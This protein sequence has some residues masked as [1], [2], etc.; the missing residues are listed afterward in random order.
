MSEV[1]NV[2]LELGVLTGKRLVLGGEVTDLCGSLDE[3]GLE[4]VALGSEVID[5]VGKLGVGMGKSMNLCGEL[6]YLFL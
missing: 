5:L 6:S 1:V 4:F 2:G 3:L